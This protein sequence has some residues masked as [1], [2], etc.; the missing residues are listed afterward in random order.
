M[1]NPI[2]SFA[3]AAIA[4]LTCVFACSARAGDTLWDLNFK[5]LEPGKPLEEVSFSRNCEGPQKVVQ[6]EADLLVGAKKVGK[7]SPALLF[8]KKTAANYTPAFTLKAP[9][10]Y[11]SGVI[12]VTFDIVFDELV[13]TAK[14]PVE[15]LISIPVLNA[16]GTAG[17]A[18]VFVGE[19]ST[20]VLV[21]GSGVLEGGKRTTLKI[22][23]VAHIKVVLNL[24]KHSFQAFVNDSPLGE[25]EPGEEKFADFLGLTVRDGTALGGN[26]GATF[27]AGIANFLVKHDH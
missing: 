6:T 23:E 19:G 3:F 10:P 24:D 16:Q 26:K 14:F 27:S 11:T 5:R 15:T 7:L 17:Y 21:S 25:E 22:G 8:T 1:K 9:S 13:Q 20:S 4:M 18:L 12:T 2:S